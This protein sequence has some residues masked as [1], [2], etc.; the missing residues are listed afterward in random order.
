MKCIGEWR[1]AKMAEWCVREF[2]WTDDGYSPPPVSMMC[3]AIMPGEFNEEHYFSSTNSTGIASVP[4]WSLINDGVYFGHLCAIVGWRWQ[5]D[6]RSISVDD[7][8]EVSFNDSIIISFKKSSPIERHLW[9]FFSLNNDCP[10]MSCC[11]LISLDFMHLTWNKTK[12]KLNFNDK[13]RV[14]RPTTSSISK[15]IISVEWQFN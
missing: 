7:V 2:V 11:P 12:R 6:G 3:A 8:V 1:K 14:H 13:V 10:M 5:N 4:K 15:R 9:F